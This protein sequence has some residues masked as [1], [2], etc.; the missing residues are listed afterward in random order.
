MLNEYWDEKDTTYSDNFYFWS[1]QLYKCF[2]ELPLVEDIE[3]AYLTCMSEQHRL[4]PK[5]EILCS[6]VLLVKHYF[7][8]MEEDDNKFKIN[9]QWCNGFET[10]KGIIGELV[11]ITFLH[12]RL[13]NLGRYPEELYKGNFYFQW[14]TRTKTQH[15][16]QEILKE[17]NG[18]QEYL[19]CPYL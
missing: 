2:N 17:R 19:R 3:S 13:S 14:P 15:V 18:D 1:D 6:I 8:T 5:Y 11:Y 12:S 10:C 16:Y 4:T 7:V 9:C